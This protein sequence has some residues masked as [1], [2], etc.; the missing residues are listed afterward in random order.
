ML[1][2]LD[3]IIHEL[4]SLRRELLIR[5]APASAESSLTRRLCG[6]LA[7][8]AQ[9]GTFDAVQEYQGISEWERF[10]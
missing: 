8:P 1:E 4:Q 3:A 6:I 2:R 9:D 5:A 7:P 10:A